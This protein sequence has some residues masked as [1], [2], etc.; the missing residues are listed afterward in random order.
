MLHAYIFYMKMGD[1]AAIKALGLTTSKLGPAQP[2]FSDFAEPDFS[3]AR[4]RGLLMLL[5]ATWR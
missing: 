1:F 5:L 4:K 2:C 3:M